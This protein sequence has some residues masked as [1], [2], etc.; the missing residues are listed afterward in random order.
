MNASLQ[1]RFAR[2]SSCR[3]A[4]VQRFLGAGSVRLPWQ[5]WRDAARTLLPLR[6]RAPYGWADGPW[7]IA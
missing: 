6:W 2:L 3:M 4:D 1:L 5:R 7:T